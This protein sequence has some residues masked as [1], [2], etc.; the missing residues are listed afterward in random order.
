MD[1]PLFGL[2]VSA[3]AASTSKP[4]VTPTFAS[5]RSSCHIDSE[6]AGERLVNQ[7]LAYVALSRGRHDAQ[8]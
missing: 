4:S 3:L 1:D 5:L 8:I 7:R 2:S 6:Q